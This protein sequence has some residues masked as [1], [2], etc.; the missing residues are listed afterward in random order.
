MLLNFKNV[1]FVGILGAAIERFTSM[2]ESFQALTS[3]Q[4]AHVVEWFSGNDRDTDRWNL[5]GGGTAV[6]QDSVDGGILVQSTAAANNKTSLNFNDK[7]HYAH[8]GSILIAVARQS[9]TTFYTGSIGLSDETVDNG[10]DLALFEMNELNTF[11]KAR[12]ADASTASSTDTTVATDTTWHSMKIELASGNIFYDI[13]GVEEVDKTTN[14]PTIKLQPI[15]FAQE[16][17]GKVGDIQCRFMEVYNTSVTINSSLYER[18]SALTQ[19]MK[20][21]VVELFSGSSLNTDRWGSTQG[22]IAMKDAVDGGLNLLTGTGSFAGADLGFGTNI[23]TN[24]KPFSHDDSKIKFLARFNN[25]NSEINIS[26]LGF[27]KEIRPDGAG[28]DAVAWQSTTF[29]SF[30]RFRTINGVPA[31]TDT[32]ST[33]SSD[34]S[35]HLFE[36]DCNASSCEGFIDGVSEVDVTTTLPSSAMQPMFG[37]RKPSGTGTAV[38]VDILYCEA[39]NKLTTETDYPSVY[40]LF[41]EDTTIGKAH[42]W[43]WCSGADNDT[44]RWTENTIS[45][46][47]TFDVF[48][49]VNGGYRIFIAASSG[50]GQYD[51]NNKR[52]YAHD[53][54]KL[55]SVFRHGAGSLQKTYVGLHGDT[56]ATPSN[57]AQHE[58]D[59]AQSF[60]RLVTKDGTTESATNTTLANSETY[61]SSMMELTASDCDLWID[62]VLEVDGKTTNLPTT[63]LQPVMGLLNN[64]S[65]NRGAYFSYIEALN[66]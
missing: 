40:N 48:D 39:Y 59:W 38:S 63:K 28:T 8:N 17:G 66:T 32:N 9:N 56:T 12:S 25:P 54:S 65:T 60:Q 3:V 10:T 26:Q 14:R 24:I 29:S 61:E 22:T 35:L 31:Q 7:H 41:R 2:Y 4:V 33:V 57:F 11:I 18:L 15:V 55:I 51:F 46:T 27:S 42:F 5:T 43:E 45:G 20:Q 36:I 16:G 13:D 52:Q 47:I 53:G 30:F 37:I 50:H 1:G 49:A 19:V 21:R 34:Q 6:M 62:G 44:F 64:G 23:T 58:Q